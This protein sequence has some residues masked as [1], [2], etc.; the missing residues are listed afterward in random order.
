MMKKWAVRLSM[1]CLCVIFL[2]RIL[3]ISGSLGSAL[4]VLQ[5]RLNAAAALMLS[6]S[7][8][9]LPEET[10]AIAPLSLATNLS[11]LPSV[12]GTEP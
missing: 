12:F 11:S 9:A 7:L 3:D 5:L 2:M 4:A 1:K 8:H 6:Q 10:E